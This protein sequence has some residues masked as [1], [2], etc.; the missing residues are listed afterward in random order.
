MGTAARSPCM[1]SF[2]RCHIDNFCINLFFCRGGKSPDPG[3]VV[4]RKTHQSSGKGRRVK[5][6]NIKLVKKKS[7]ETAIFTS[8]F[9]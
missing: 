4:L 8:S 6:G 3:T 9:H 7:L 2:L 1:F 5:G